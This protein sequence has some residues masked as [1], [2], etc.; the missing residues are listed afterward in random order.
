MN[1]IIVLLVLL[2]VCVLLLFGLVS[3]LED[4]S[5]RRQQR[6]GQQHTRSQFVWQSRSHFQGRD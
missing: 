3:V 4:L 2:G 6:S 1:T 5:H